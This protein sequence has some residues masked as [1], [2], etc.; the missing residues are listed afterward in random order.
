MATEIQ[1]IVLASIRLTLVLAGTAAA[2]VFAVNRKF[3][4]IKN[5]FDCI[6]EA[7][8]SST[9]GLQNLIMQHNLSLIHI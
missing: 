1:Y 4:K 7:I 3:D 5:R 8:K 2:T 9:D 6:I